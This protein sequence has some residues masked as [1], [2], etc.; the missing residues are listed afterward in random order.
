M[1]GQETNEPA[2]IEMRLDKA[3]EKEKLCDDAT[4]T[5]TA[6]CSESETC[7]SGKEASPERSSS[8]EKQDQL[9]TL[10]NRHMVRSKR[11]ITKAFSCLEDTTLDGAE[12]VDP[13]P[14][15]EDCA[16]NSNLNKPAEFIEKIWRVCN[17]GF[18]NSWNA[19]EGD[20]KDSVEKDDEETSVEND[21]TRLSPVPFNI[22][23]KV[24]SSM[25]H[26]H[27][28]LNK[29]FITPSLPQF[30]MDDFVPSCVASMKR[31]NSIPSMIFVAAGEWPEDIS[32]STT[33]SII[34]S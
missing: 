14:I 32:I 34:R 5:M 18:C 20:D 8:L 7:G 28:R 30:V 15:A 23:S 21:H 11:V 31:K 22:P 33:G 13:N 4:A 24:P 6:S 27:Q 2:L 29:N 26:T 9:L 3:F 1:T 25:K 10:V 12:E 16:M 19:D 17:T